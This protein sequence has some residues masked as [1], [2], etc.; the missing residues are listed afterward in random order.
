MDVVEAIKEQTNSKS[1][2]A[3][4]SNI[5]ISVPK[6]KNESNKKVKE[7]IDEVKDAVKDLG[8]ISEEPTKSK[9]L[10]SIVS[11]STTIP[12]LEK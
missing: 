10:K 11:E 5:Q 1:K 8:K 9:S 3:I 7:A 2:S 12:D 4:A 6:K